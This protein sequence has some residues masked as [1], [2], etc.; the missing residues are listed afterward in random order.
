MSW[1]LKDLIVLAWHLPS[2]LWRS[3]IAEAL[4]TKKRPP[5]DTS[6]QPPRKSR[7]ALTPEGKAK[8]KA[9]AAK[10]K[11]KPKAKSNAKS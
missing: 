3:V 9:G 2:R 1:P 6:A 5:E 4:K 11:A 8:A 10:G 7:A